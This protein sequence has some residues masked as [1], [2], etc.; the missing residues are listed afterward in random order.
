MPPFSVL[1]SL[2]LLG[3]SSYTQVILG[4]GLTLLSEATSC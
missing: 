2:T 1:H 4:E 3:V